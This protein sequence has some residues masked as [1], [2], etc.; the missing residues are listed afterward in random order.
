MEAQSFRVYRLFFDLTIVQR[1]H[2]QE[3]TADTSTIPSTP[4]TSTY[5]PSKE[6]SVPCPNLALIGPVSKSSK[7]CVKCQHTFYFFA[8]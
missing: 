7:L 5:S 6:F 4:N 3:K 1:S 2:V 8:R